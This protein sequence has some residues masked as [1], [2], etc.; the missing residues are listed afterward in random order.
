METVIET[1]VKVG[2]KW[3]HNLPDGT[4]VIYGREYTTPLTTAQLEEL[5]NK[6]C[7]HVRKAAKKETKETPSEV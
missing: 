5:G 1:W 2:N 6:G 3:E 7:P 4:H